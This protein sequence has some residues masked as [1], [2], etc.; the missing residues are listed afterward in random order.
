FL[1][2]LLLNLAASSTGIP[3][4]TSSRWI[5]DRAGRRVKLTCVNWISHNEPMVAEGLEKKPLAYIAKAIA[6]A[7]FNCVR[8]TWPTFMFTRPDYGKLTVGQS[9]DRYGLTAA[10][11]GIS[12][13]NP[14]LMG[15]SVVEVHGAV[16]DELG[17][18]GLMVVLDNHVSH[19]QWC[20][21]S[22]DGNGFFGDYNFDPDEWIRGL[23]AV[24]RAYKSR[25]GVVGMS[26]R[27]ELRG[28]KQNE[29]DWYRYM[30]AGAAAVHSENPDFLVI[31]SGLNFDTN[32]GFLR[33]KPLPVGNLDNKL[34]YE[35]HW[36][37]FGRPLDQLIHQT[38][39]ICH[40]MTSGA[41][42]NFLFLTQSF[43]VFLSEFG[44]DQT[45]SNEGDNRYISC[46]L[47][48]AAEIDVD[49]AL[50]TFQGSYIFRENKTNGDE[51]YG[52][53][54]F[55]WDKPKNPSF[56]NRLEMI[57][58]MNQGMAGESK[59]KIFHPQSGLCAVAGTAGVSLGDCRSATLWDSHQDGGEIRLANSQLCISPGNADG[60]PVSLSANNCGVTW[61]YGSSSGLQ[62]AT[63]YGGGH[64]C[65]EAG[66]GAV[67]T[68]KCLC[69]DDHNLSDFPTCADNPEVQWFKL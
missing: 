47:A 69:I 21:G 4:S 2:L 49:W 34:V 33:S 60:A 11:A 35:G 6:S 53:M 36:Y 39:S 19:P 27:N 15:M 26:L 23:T 65:L 10:K 59:F 41:Y 54:D 40:S 57:R 58:Q 30:A 17:R 7:G 5:V 29:A 24:A 51:S 52:V 67:L 3:L 56:L 31:I 22:D 50:W 66:N 45:G 63:A 38:N 43:P 16:V 14:Q 61:N 42:N 12:K 48:A 13:N 18:S 20:C 46:L 1:L 44:I 37:A 55:N 62:L 8:F 68:K 9:L 32:L 64:V 25:P 28:P